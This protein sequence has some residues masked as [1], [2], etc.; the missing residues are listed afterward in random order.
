MTSWLLVFV[1]GGLGSMCRYGI[2]RL[3]FH[4]NF[5][6][7]TFAANAISSFLLGIFLGLSLKTW[8]SSKWQLLLMVGFCGGFSTFSTFSGETLQL[9]QS[10]QYGMAAVYVLGSVVICMGCIFLGMWLTGE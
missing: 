3:F 10:G 8:S 5:L 9:I 1:G 7:S 4:S 2:S 6:Y